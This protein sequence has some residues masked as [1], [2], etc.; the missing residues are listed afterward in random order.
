MTQ[1]AGL[2]I[3]GPMAGQANVSRSNV[4]K[5]QVQAPKNLKEQLEA[6]VADTPWETITYNW[7]HTGGLGLW[8]VE[9]MNMNDAISAMAEAYAE[10]MNAERASRTGRPSRGSAG[11]ED[12]G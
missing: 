11:A 3:G 1:Y 2:C 6:S 4:F 8:I 10:K 5:V 7:L 12:S 9:G